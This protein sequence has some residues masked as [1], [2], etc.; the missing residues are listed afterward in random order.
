M[1]HEAIP[2]RLMKFRKDAGLSRAKL[3]E[4]SGVPM[5]TIADWELGN[6]VPRDVYQIWAV[7]HAL[8]LTVETY[9]GLE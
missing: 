2:A 4:V 8:G 1:N 3:F 7:A 9:L 6:R 5:R